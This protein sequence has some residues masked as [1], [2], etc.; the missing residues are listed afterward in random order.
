MKEYNDKNRD[1]IRESVRRVGLFFAKKNN[2]TATFILVY[3]ESVY[4][5][6]VDLTISNHDTEITINLWSLESRE[7]D[8]EVKRYESFEK[9]LTKRVDKYLKY[10]TEL[11]TI[12]KE[13][14]KE[15]F[16]VKM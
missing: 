11:H 1:Y 7:L 10:M 14:P 16:P 8:D 15:S 12:V 6:C 9:Y 13:L 2:R 5:A 3:K 4:D